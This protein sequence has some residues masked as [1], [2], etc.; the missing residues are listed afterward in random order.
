M[1]RRI[2]TLT[3][4]FASTLFAYSN[5]FSQVNMNKWIQLKVEIG[6]EI[7]ITIA[8]DS[9]GARAYVKNGNYSDRYI[10]MINDITFSQSNFFR[11]FDTII[12]I[13]GDVSQI[14]I[15]ETSFKLREIKFDFN[16][17]VI[18][19]DLVTNGLN[20]IDLNPLTKLE[21]LSLSMVN[22]IEYIDA[23]NLTHLYYLYV[24][25]EKLKD[26]NI[27]GSLNI[28]TLIFNNTHISSID[29]SD[30]KKLRV[31]Y[32]YCTDLTS[33]ALDSLYCSLPAYSGIGNDYGKIVVYNDYCSSFYWEVMASDTKNAISKG[34]YVVDRSFQLMPKTNGTFYCSSISTHEINLDEIEAKVYPNPAIDK[35]NIE[36][37]ETVKRLEA[38]DALGRKVI[39]KTPNQNNFSIDISSLEKG[40]YILKLQTE[41]G[42]GSY[43]IMKN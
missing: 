4:V 29:I 10:N 15:W 30:L 28:Q 1:K 12:T 18:Y 39:S 35:L 31:I 42:V 9:S 36:T 20:G 33:S 25:G 27:K 38:F 13:Y 43:K 24:G 16:N 34:W 6:A 21:F 7:D 19:L 5:L 41:E 26:L 3:L 40:I 14:S 32:C 37:K 23:S 17:D 2:I 11:A 8:S 22:Y